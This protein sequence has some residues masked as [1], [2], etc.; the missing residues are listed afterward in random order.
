MLIDE[1]IETFEKAKGCRDDNFR[2]C[3]WKT[4]C[5]CQNY[6]SQ[7]KREEMFN[8]ILM[9]LKQEKWAQDKIKEMR[10]EED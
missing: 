1:L 2:R 7:E 6:I 9:R 3:S 4:C 10:A 8:D 5:C